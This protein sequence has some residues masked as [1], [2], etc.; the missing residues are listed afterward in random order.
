MT[1]QELQLLSKLDFVA[2]SVSLVL[3]FTISFNNTLRVCILQHL[4][5]FLCNCYVSW[6]LLR[7]QKVSLLLVHCKT[8]EMI[9]FTKLNLHAKDLYD[10]SCVCDLVEVL[11][12][13]FC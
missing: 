11:C 1:K 4:S 13:F 7:F 2:T 6:R 5:Y 8:R 10:L 9:C 3:Q 12:W